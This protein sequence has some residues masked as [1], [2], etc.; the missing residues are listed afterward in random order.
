MAKQ[1][2]GISRKILISVATAAICGSAAASLFIWKN[3]MTR[4]GVREQIKL[5]SPYNEDKPLVRR[6]M[7]HDIPE[8]QH[9][10]D[11]V[12]TEQHQQRGILEAIHRG[13][14]G[15]PDIGENP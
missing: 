9:K 6:M 5:E 14:G 13:M 3:Y 1:V 11:D 4:E 2:D 10:L 7:E 15:R 8:M 12:R